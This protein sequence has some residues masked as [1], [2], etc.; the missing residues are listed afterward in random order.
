MVPK[1][2]EFFYGIPEHARGGYFPWWL[3]NLHRLETPITKEEAE[4]REAATLFDNAIPYLD[5]GDRKT[6]PTELQ[7]VAKRDSFLMLALVLQS[8][9][10]NPIM[11]VYHS[12]AFVT[13]SKYAEESEL[14]N[15]YRRLLV[16]SDSSSLSTFNNGR[17]SP[18]HHATFTQFWRAY[19]SGTIIQLIDS[20]GLKKLRTRLPHLEAFLSVPPTA[21]QPSVW[22]LKQCIEIDDPI[23]YPPIPSLARDYGFSNC[24]NIEYTFTLM[25]IYKKVLQ[26]AVP[27]ELYKACVAGRLFEFVGQFLDMEEDWRRLLWNPYPLDETTEVWH[28]VKG[29]LGMTLG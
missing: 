11:E 6:H 27:M 3:E 23:Q 12:F 7:P 8:A 20:H 25:E 19:E 13:C 26:E 4:Q 18:T 22:D 17:N 10:P 21:A 1:I 15:I 28:V 14:L 9:T 29:I 2:K 24:A 16:P 5:P